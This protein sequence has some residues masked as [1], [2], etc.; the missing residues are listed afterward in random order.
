MIN[1]EKIQNEVINNDVLTEKKLDVNK[2]LQTK[3]ICSGTVINVDFLNKMFSTAEQDIEVIDTALEELYV[4][5]NNAKTSI[6]E[7]TDKLLSK[8]SHLYTKY[9]TYNFYCSNYNNDIYGIVEDY[10]SYND[11]IEYND[12]EIDTVAGRL[13]LKPIESTKIDTYN[14]SAQ[15]SSPTGYVESGNINNIFD[16]NSDSYFSYADDFTSKS[17]TLDTIV[18]FKSQKVINKISIS[19]NNFNT[20]NYITLNSIKYSTDGVNYID[21]YNGNSVY[22]DHIINSVLSNTELNPTNNGGSNI[23]NF[24]FQPIIASHIKFTFTQNKLHP[25][26]NTYKIGLFDISFYNCKYS[27]SGSIILKKKIDDLKKVKTISLSSISLTDVDSSMLKTDFYISFDNKTWYQIRPLESSIKND[28]PEI[29]YINS[30]WSENS[31]DIDDNKIGSYLYLKV[32]MSRNNSVSDLKKILA[33][34]T[35]VVS[36]NFDISK[37][38]PKTIKLS[39]KAI[40]ASIKVFVSPF[41]SAGK[42]NYNKLSIG[43]VVNKQLVYLLNSPVQLNG[44]ESLYIGTSLLDRFE[45]VDSLSSAN[46]SG[47]ILDI[48]KNQI[49][50]KLAKEELNRQP[51]YYTDDWLD[52]IL[53][54]S[55]DISAGN[56]LE[57]YDNQTFYLEFPHDVISPVGTVISL[58]RT[59]SGNKNNIRIWRMFVDTNN[60][61]IKINI[62]EIISAGKKRIPLSYTPLKTHDIIL[63]GGAYYQID[64]KDGVSEFIDADE[65]AFSIDY[66]NKYLYL[67]DALKVDISISYTAERIS[68]VPSSEYNLSDNNT[69]VL[70][71]FPSNNVL[72][73]IEYDIVSELS[74]NL[75]TVSSNSTNTSLIIDSEALENYLNDISLKNKYI[76][77]TYN[78][79]SNIEN[80]IKEIKTS[81]SPILDK[82]ILKYA[83][84]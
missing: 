73:K 9:H 18:N 49:I 10:N 34:T 72:Y 56:L 22:T 3:S 27:D 7:S 59:C 20:S 12:V 14:I 81:I 64:F 79:M 41:V 57:S 2:L 28:I 38:I 33:S 77:V 42:P 32:S 29:L 30:L 39:N 11:V 82:T 17:L 23:F 4:N 46:I 83:I 8:L 19:P 60:E 78:Y 58:T 68:E 5:T 55:N 62:A 50:V 43:K 75:F 53:S 21:I 31:I 51:G 16:D 54:Q 1:L 71:K 66:T 36:D 37:E 70:S 40:E 26:D 67:R 74:S 24:Y 48:E 45:T 61:I 47:F 65:Y 13:H 63:G 25:V 69:I 6:I 44:T 80:F 76:V 15:Y 52:P 35:L 84:V